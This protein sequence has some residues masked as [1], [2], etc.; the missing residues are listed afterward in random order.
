[1]LSKQIK[2]PLPYGRIIN[3]FGQEYGIDLRSDID[4]KKVFIVGKNIMLP[5]KTQTEASLKLTKWMINLAKDYIPKRTHEIANEYAFKFNLIR[6][7]THR[8]RWG[9]CSSKKNLNFNYR[10]ITTPAKC[11]DYVIIHELAHTVEMNHSYRF[12]D[13]VEKCMK[14]YKIWKKILRKYENRL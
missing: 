14:D 4:S 7:K 10:L 12:W 5:A 1:M 2:T 3:L 11:I 8:T 9:S 6:I 13:L